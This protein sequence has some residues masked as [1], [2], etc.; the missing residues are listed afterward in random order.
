MFGTSDIVQKALFGLLKTLCN[1]KD[2]AVSSTCCRWSSVQSSPALEE[3]HHHV[4]DVLWTGPDWQSPLVSS[5]VLL[6]VF[7]PQFCDVAEVTIDPLEDLAKLGYKP[8]MDY[9]TLIILLYFC[10]HTENQISKSDNFHY[11]SP[12]F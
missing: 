10:R 9:K 4:Q 6:S 1:S 3:L 7:F 11:Y 5:P 12:L 8:Y 2:A